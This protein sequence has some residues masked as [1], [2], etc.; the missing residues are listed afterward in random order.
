MKFALIALLAI[1][2]TGC[3]KTLYNHR[4]DFSPKKGKGPWTDKYQERADAQHEDY[5]Y[6]GK[7]PL[8]PSR[9]STQATSI[10]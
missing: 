3:S 7:R 8:F 10:P 5:Q 1:S 4:E 9:R 6:S 2:F